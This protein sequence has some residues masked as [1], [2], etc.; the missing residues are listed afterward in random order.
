MR[1]VSRG[2]GQA[3]LT[4]K[5]LLLRLLKTDPKPNGCHQCGASTDLTRHRFAFAKLLSVKREWAKRLRAR[6]FRQSA[7]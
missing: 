7:S 5:D 3:P 1:S 4:E 2:S 6:A